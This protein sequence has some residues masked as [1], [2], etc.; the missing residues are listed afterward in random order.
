MVSPFQR[1]LE[2]KQIILGSFELQ[3]T[4]CDVFGTARDMKS[5][6]NV[7]IV[8]GVSVIQHTAIL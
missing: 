5:S 3:I 1:K 6:K 8:V 4:L 2:Q 7:S